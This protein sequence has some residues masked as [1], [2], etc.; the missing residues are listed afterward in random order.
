[1][2]PLRWLDRA[3]ARLRESADLGLV[4]LSTLAVQPLVPAGHPAAAGD[5]VPW[6][7]GCVSLVALIRGRRLGPGPHPQ[8]RARRAPFERLLRHLAAALTPMALLGWYRFGQS[9][10]RGELSDIVQ[11]LAVGRWTGLAG[12]AWGALGLGVA[13]AIAG[14]V[15]LAPDDG[16]TAWR[17]AGAGPVRLLLVGAGGTW[18]GAVGAGL[19][20]GWFAPLGPAYG[21]SLLRWFPEGVALGLGF[22]A[23]GLVCGRPAHLDQRRA[24]G[25]RDGRPVRLLSDTLLWAA[26]GPSA[27]LWVT[28]QLI[29]LIT[30]LTVAYESAHVVSLHVCAWGAVLWRRATPV[31]VDC[32]LHE[33]APAGGRDAK[34]RVGFD[35]P[36]EGALRINPLQVVPTRSIHPWRVPLLRARIDDLDDPIRPLWERP[37]PPPA[38][39]LLGDAWFEPDPLTGRPQVDEITVHLGEGRDLTVIR[40]ED[41]QTRRM[42]VLRPFPRDRTAGD[43]PPRTYTWEADLPPGAV[44]VVDA[45]T[46]TLRLRDGDL[47][48]VSSE[49]VARAFLLELGALVDEDGGPSRARLPQMEDYTRL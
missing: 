39:H 14:V 15:V 28:M 3:G 23:V 35:R 33:V 5:L 17:P 29:E 18:L 6:A 46:R 11:D 38:H 32:L 40:D 26:L 4:W 37:S 34:G 41:V 44:Q 22:L 21:F 49:G 30:G 43:A 36:P 24:A 31:A 48:V 19:L 10:A 1:M 47:I 8:L 13:A 25:R 12:L 2:S 27:L 45:A 42:V 20:S 7:L 16:R 9:V